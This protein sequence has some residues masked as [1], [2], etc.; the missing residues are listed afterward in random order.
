MN[1]DQCH[2]RLRGMAHYSVSVVLWHW[3]KSCPRQ[4]HIFF[5]GLLCICAFLVTNKTYSSNHKKKILSVDV[6]EVHTSGG[7]GSFSTL[8]TDLVFFVIADRVHICGE[9]S[10]YCS[11]QTS[12]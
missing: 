12:H 5:S 6:V 8:V 11:I 4:L 3:L 7:N 10:V 9:F 2:H 1:R